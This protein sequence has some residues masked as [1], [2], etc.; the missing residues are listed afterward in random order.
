MKHAEW[1]YQITVET[2]YYEAQSSVLSKAEFRRVKCMVDE[3]VRHKFLFVKNC[4]EWT[5]SIES[6]FSKM[7]Q[8]FQK[9]THSANVIL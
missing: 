8:Q 4:V 3:L 9:Y 5:I 1:L 2:S 6:T 7:L